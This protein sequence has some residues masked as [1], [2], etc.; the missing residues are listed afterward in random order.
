MRKYLT[1]ILFFLLLT[2]VFS[3]TSVASDLFV[4]SKDTSLY[5]YNIKTTEQVKLL[6]FKEKLK[7][8]SLKFSK[9]SVISFQLIHN[10]ENVAI[11]KE[12]GLPMV[13]PKT[14]DDTLI[15]KGIMDSWEYDCF[16]YFTTSY[17]NYDLKNG[18]FFKYEEVIQVQTD[19]IKTL[20]IVQIVKQFNEK[21]EVIAKKQEVFECRMIAHD[22]GCIECIQ[23]KGIRVGTENISHSEKVNNI[24]FFT[25]NG[26]LFIQKGFKQKLI[27]KHLSFY[28]Y[29]LGNGFYE[30]T[31]SIDGESLVVRYSNGN[32]F[33]DYK[34]YYYFFNLKTFQKNIETIRGY[35]K[36]RFISDGKDLLLRSK[37]Y[38]AEIFIY[39]IKTKTMKVIGKG[40][41]YAYQR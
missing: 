1:F 22:A 14:Y 36:P 35:E 24:Q 12:T 13:N 39:N 7:S 18:S 21:G 40:V 8:N 38:K 19:T 10:S 37:E 30:P 32:Y 29:K 41:E 34:T 17:W 5:L 25:K 23:E 16:E 31:L 33:D 6:D 4:Y 3:Q 20:S 15:Y 9:D 2:Q 27:F 26:N 28:N 11:H